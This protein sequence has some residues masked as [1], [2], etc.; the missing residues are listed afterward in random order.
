M[1]AVGYVAL[2]VVLPL[3]VADTL[4]FHPRARGRSS[5]KMAEGELEML[6][7]K[8]LGGQKPTNLK[9]FV[10]KNC[11][12]NTGSTFNL[13]ITPDPIQFPGTLN[14]DADIDLKQAIDSPLAVSLKMKRNFN[15]NWIE[16]PCIANI[17]SCTYTSL[18][19]ALA[20]VSCPPQLTKAGIGC[21]CPFKAKTYTVKGMSIDVD[22]SAFISGEFQVQANVTF[23]TDSKYNQCIDAQFT[24]A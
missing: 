19:E 1:N 17:G 5:S 4:R 18:C 3:V 13:N 20:P 7:E 16:V 2:F 12:G 10:F 8:F 11:G 24:V 22:A 23:G 14:I 9:D 15:G 6:A 21:H